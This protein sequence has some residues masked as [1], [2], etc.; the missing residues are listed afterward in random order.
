MLGVCVM[1]SAMGD[2][3]LDFAMFTPPETAQ[4]KLPDPVVSWLVKPNA[5]AYCQHVQMKDGYVTRPEG[6]VFWQI[7]ASRCTIVTT[8]NTTHSLLGH[9]FV[10]CLQTR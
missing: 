8:G 5:S 9:L 10:H 2:P 4:R 1:A 6:C 7:Q 3:L